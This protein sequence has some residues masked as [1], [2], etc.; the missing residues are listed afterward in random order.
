MRDL[1]IN[2][3]LYYLISLGR[4]AIIKKTSTIKKLIYVFVDKKIG[5]KS[6]YYLLW[7]K[8]CKQGNKLVIRSVKCTISFPRTSS[9]VTHKQHLSFLYFAIF[10]SLNLSHFCS[11]PLWLQIHLGFSQYFFLHMTQ[12]SYIFLDC[13]DCSIFHVCFR[14]FFYNSFRFSKAFKCFFKESVLSHNVCLSV[15]PLFM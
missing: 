3:S 7:K 15:C 13:M 9:R 2:N 11:W 6:K 14:C 10:L 8:E 5:K 1:Y 4:H 12:F